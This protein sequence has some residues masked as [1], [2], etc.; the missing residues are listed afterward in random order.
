MSMHVFISQ[1]SAGRIERDH[2]NRGFRDRESQSA[3]GPMNMRVLKD[4]MSFVL[5][6]GPPQNCN[7]LGIS[8]WEKKKG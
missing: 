8:F 6:S 5:D 3:S 4:T 2:L 7:F 1:G